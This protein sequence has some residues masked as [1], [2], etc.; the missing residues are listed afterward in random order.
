MEMLMKVLNGQ[1][2][3]E[4]VTDVGAQ[5]DNS[6]FFPNST[7]DDPKFAMDDVY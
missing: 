2:I 3:L 6:Y 1:I 4:G 7:A 5:F